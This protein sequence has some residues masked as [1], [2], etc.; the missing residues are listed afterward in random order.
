MGLKRAE[1]KGSQN[2][3]RGMEEE[4]ERWEM[5]AKQMEGLKKEAQSAERR[6]REKGRVNKEGGREGGV[7][8]RARRQRMTRAE[9]AGAG[10]GGE[11]VFIRHHV[12]LPRSS[13]LCEHVRKIPPR[14]CCSHVHSA[15]ESRKR[16]ED[17]AW[18]RFQPK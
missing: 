3:M 17:E 11:A 7:E 16:S 4:E 15:S 9:G 2:M 12:L 6:G 5:R 18:R 14:L 10:A 1:L 8:R 13:S